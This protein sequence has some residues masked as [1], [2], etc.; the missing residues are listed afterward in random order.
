[1]LKNFS[2]ENR[3][4]VSV[5][6]EIPGY[7]SHNF[8]GVVFISDTTYLCVN[9]GDNVGCITTGSIQYFQPDPK[10]K[11]ITAQEFFLKFN[12]ATDLIYGAVGQTT[13]DQAGPVQE[14]L[15]NRLK[16]LPG[17]GLQTLPEVDSDKIDDL[18]HHR[19]DETFTEGI[20][21]D[22]AAGMLL[23]RDSF[24]EAIPLGSQ[25]ILSPDVLDV[26][27]G[28][29]ATELDEDEDLD[30]PPAKSTPTHWTN[31]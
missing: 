1:M 24:T 16:D 18:I 17:I 12:A 26:K 13:T 25:E 27:A 30:I 21:V 8:G 20:L 19:P 28:L 9:G 15:N 14:I 4:T 23:H 3:T 6:L 7:Y 11:A 22:P 10:A 31:D 2:I 5:D 29:D